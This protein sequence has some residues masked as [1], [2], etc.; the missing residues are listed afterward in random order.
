MIKR[1]PEKHVWF[2]LTGEKKQT[3]VYDMDD[4]HV[5]FF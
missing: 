3:H 2:V 5:V 4:I 1:K